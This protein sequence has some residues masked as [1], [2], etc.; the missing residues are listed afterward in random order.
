MDLGLALGLSLGI[1]IPV[2]LI[3]GAV[4]G[5]VIS[6]KYFKKQL[7]ENPPITREQIKAMWRSM[8]RTPSEAQIN[9]VMEEMKRKQK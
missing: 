6:Q 8:G 4:I 1:G 5:F 7:K 9:A 2:S 3:I